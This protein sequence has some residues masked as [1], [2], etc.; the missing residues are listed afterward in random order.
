MPALSIG[1]SKL[2]APFPSLFLFLFL[3][4]WFVLF[5]GWLFLVSG[6]L[7][8]CLYPCGGVLG[9]VLGVA[10]EVGVF[11]GVV[12]LVVEGLESYVYFVDLG[13]CW[14]YCAESCLVSYGAWFLVGYGLE[15]V[16]DFLVCDVRF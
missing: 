9:E 8:G 16:L 12:E 10:L 1:A 14:P 15:G 11:L 6:E 13:G 4:V 5:V 2:G 3:F 7:F